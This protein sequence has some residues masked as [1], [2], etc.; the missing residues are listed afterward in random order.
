MRRGGAE[1]VYPR[2]EAKVRVDNILQLRMAIL[3]LLAADT[4]SEFGLGELASLAEQPRDPADYRPE[5]PPAKLP[6]LFQTP[7]WQKL[8][9]ELGLSLVAFNQGPLGHPRV[10]PTHLCTNLSLQWLTPAT[11]CV[12]GCDRSNNTSQ[13]K[14]WRAWAPGLVE[15]IVDALDSFGIVVLRSFMRLLRTRNA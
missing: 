3:M 12:E 5:I 2:K 4:N 10:K 7:K 11:A 13:S 15:A 14:L 1:L 6:S 8:R 9:K